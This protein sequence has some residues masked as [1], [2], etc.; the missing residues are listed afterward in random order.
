VLSFGDVIHGNLAGKPDTPVPIQSQSTPACNGVLGALY[1]KAP[2]KSGHMLSRL[3]RERHSPPP[4]IS[5]FRE[6]S[7]KVRGTIEENVLFR[8]DQDMEGH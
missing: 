2:T 7:R 6:Y 8:D 1:S 4:S 3:N 5:D